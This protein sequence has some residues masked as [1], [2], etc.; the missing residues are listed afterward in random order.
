MSEFNNL[1]CKKESEVVARLNPAT[2][3]GMK[4]KDKEEKRKSV[5]KIINALLNS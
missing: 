2:Q 4:M 5:E 3:N 1:L